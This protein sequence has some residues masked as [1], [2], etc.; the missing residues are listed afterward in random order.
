MLISDNLRLQDTDVDPEFEEYRKN[1]RI[2]N[3]TL[4]G[5]RGLVQSSFTTKELREMTKLKDVKLYITKEDL[6]RS[7]N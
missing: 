1:R 7:M 4:Y 2:K 6:E 5:R 3:V